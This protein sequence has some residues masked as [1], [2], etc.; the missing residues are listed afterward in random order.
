MSYEDLSDPQRHH[1]VKWIHSADKEVNVTRFGKFVLDV[2]PHLL[3][4]TFT[5]QPQ[6]VYDFC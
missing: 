6:L 4:D 1:L 2:P 5:E 3:I